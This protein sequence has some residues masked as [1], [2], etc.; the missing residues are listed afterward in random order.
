MGYHEA[1]IPGMEYVIVYKIAA[2]NVYILGIF[3]TLENYAE[4]MKILWHHFTP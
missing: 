2:E 1:R 3:H 4:K